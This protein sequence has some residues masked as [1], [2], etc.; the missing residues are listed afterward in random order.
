V[1]ILFKCV[2]F[3]LRVNSLN[4]YTIYDSRALLEITNQRRSSNCNNAATLS[5]SLY[6]SLYLSLSLPDAPL[7][8]AKRPTF[9]DDASDAVPRVT[10]LVLTWDAPSDAPVSTCGTTPSVATRHTL[11][12]RGTA[13]LHLSLESDARLDSSAFFIQRLRQCQ[14]VI[15]RCLLFLIT[16]TFHS[17]LR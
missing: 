2:C 14:L 15:L 9:D 5:L 4:L 17:L 11:A 1:R 10:P 16:P 8:I 3:I 13:D 6:R 12:R 7:C